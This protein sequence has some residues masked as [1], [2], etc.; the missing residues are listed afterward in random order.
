M[1]TS[2]SWRTRA[3]AWLA[4]GLW[5]L[6]GAA[7]AV[8][9]PGSLA[10]SGEWRRLG[11]GSA[12]WLGFHLYDA[13]LWA[14]PAGFSWSRPFALSLRYARDFSR[15]RLASSSVDEIRRLG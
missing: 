4:V 11:S 8:D 6:G 7:A 13:A 12:H 15:E 14:P 1:S 3:R 9:L 10:A 5:S 2:S